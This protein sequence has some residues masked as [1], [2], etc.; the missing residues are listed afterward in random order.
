MEEKLHTMF[1]FV[2]FSK[3]RDAVDI[4]LNLLSCFFISWRLIMVGPVRRD[5]CGK[6]K[7]TNHVV[8]CEIV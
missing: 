6:K 4:I 1:L 5:L 7:F 2:I 8:I 3:N